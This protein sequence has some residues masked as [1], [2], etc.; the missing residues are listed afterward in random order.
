VVYTALAT[1]RSAY[2][3]LQLHEELSTTMERIVRE[4]RKIP[5]SVSAGTKAPDIASVTAS[6]ITYSTSSSFALS[7]SSINFVDAGATAVTL[8]SGVTSFSIQC[9]NESNAALA[10]TLSGA[11]CYPIRRI[12][13][14]I[15]CQRDGV[16]ET[17]RTRLFIRETMSGGAS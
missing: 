12:Q 4:L 2:T 14:Q 5:L 15:S 9:Y 3:T 10:A 11:A 7:G 1:H 8:L 6:S 13:V 17:V 16:T